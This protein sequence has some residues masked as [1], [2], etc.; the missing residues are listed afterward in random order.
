MRDFQLVMAGLDPA[1]HLLRKTLARMDGYA[2]LRLAEGASA[3]Q[4]GR[5]LDDFLDV[6]ANSPFQK[7]ARFVQ[8]AE[9]QPG[10]RKI[11]HCAFFAVDHGEHQHDLAAGIAHRIDGLDGRSRRWW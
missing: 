8:R 5:A 6:R 3:P 7:L 10:L 9:C 11:F 4:A 1:I 2:G